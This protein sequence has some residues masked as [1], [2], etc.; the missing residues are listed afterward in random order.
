MRRLS[1]VLLYCG[2]LVVVFGLAKLHAAQAATVTYDFTASTRLWWTTFFAVVLSLA[3]FSAGLPDLVVGRRAIALAA[4]VA[5]VAGGLGVSIAQLALG[6]ALLPRFVVFGS[7]AVLA[8]FYVLCAELSDD[9]RSR[10]INRDRIIV[11]GDWADAA[12]LS[13]ELERAPERPA[14]IVDVL[15]PAEAMRTLSG[16]L[17]LCEMARLGNVSVVVLDR[18]AQLDRSI[19]EQAAVL[20]EE[21]VRIRTLSLFYE[22]WLGKLPISELERVSLMFDIGEL[23]RVRYGRLKRM[24]DVAFASIGVVALVVVLP[25]VVLGN[26]IA[27]RGS[28]FFRQQRVGRGARTITILK[29]RTMRGARDGAGEWTAVDDPR[30]TLF[31]KWL[32]RSHID[33]L[34]QVLNILRG[35]LSLVGPRPEQLHYVNELSEK[36]P[37]YRLR[38]LVRPGLTG[39]AQVKYPYAASDAD[40]TE[41]LQYEFYYLRHQGLLFDLKIVTRTVRTIVL[42]VNR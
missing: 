32:R 11:I 15:T 31:G 2:T 16:E 38:H 28:L 12:E 30:I 4:G 42:G 40:A 29:F 5:T 7:M 39:W 24:I 37:F 22:E 10:A 20:H 27:N 41:K 33:E 21:G 19:V 34:P 18:S 35:D 3:A 9:G 23:H 26:V 25:F 14:R 1:R 13:E 6:A 17:P 36:L 8:P